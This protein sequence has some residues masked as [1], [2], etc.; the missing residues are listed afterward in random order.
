MIRFDDL[1]SDPPLLKRK[2]IETMSIIEKVSA[3]K[4]AL[5][6]ERNVAVAQRDACR[7]TRSFCSSYRN[8]SAHCSA[9]DRRRWTPINCSSCCPQTIDFA[10]LY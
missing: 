3:E 9:A 8:T 5:A 2:L 1:P 6:D 4:I 10:P 7:R